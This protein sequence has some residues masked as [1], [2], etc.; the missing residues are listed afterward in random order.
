[1]EPHEQ[2]TALLV[3]RLSDVETVA[4]QSPKVHNLLTWCVPHLGLHGVTQVTPCQVCN[5]RTWSRPMPRNPGHDIVAP[6]RGAELRH[7]ASLIP[8][9]RRG[10]IVVGCTVAG[11]RAQPLH[12]PRSGASRGGPALGQVEHC[13]SWPGSQ[14]RK[15]RRGRQV[16]QIVQ[17]GAGLGGSARPRERGD[18]CCVAHSHNP[19]YGLP[20]PI[21]IARKL[22]R[23][24]EPTMARHWTCPY[25]NRDCTIGDNDIRGMSSY[26]RI[27]KE[28][29]YNLVSFT[30]V[31]CPNPDCRQRVIFASLWPCDSVGN[32]DYDSDP[33]FRW[34]LVPESEAR[35]FP[36]YIPVQLRNDYAEACLIRGKSPKASATLSRRCLQGII[37][38]F[39][40]IK[41]GRLV[42]E[43]HALEEKIDPVTWGAI[44]AVRHV[45]N[46]GAHM[47]KDVNL[48]IDVEPEEAGLLIELIE[49]LFREW[50][51]A[52][53]DRE[54][55]MQAIRKMA[56]DKKAAQQKPPDE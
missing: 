7:V 30:I 12:P 42:D 44:D 17:A 51:M 14:G 13:A 11:R 46:I 20:R 16:A 41:K 35:P 4:A 3:D 36:D 9:N 18:W 54:T 53:H 45:G 10:D 31:V 50:Y 5:L 34:N 8:R 2:Q 39:W 21:P 43:I 23:R 15:S 28:Y 6:S 24:K 19:L 37:R 33:L 26:T 29:G 47:E 1:M 52:R 38:D 48:M 22:A 49:T 56:D 40:G 25:C 32:V 27:A 55:R